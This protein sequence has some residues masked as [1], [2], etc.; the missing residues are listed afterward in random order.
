MR[1]VVTGASG[2]CGAAVA[3]AA[4]AAG[5][6]VVSVGRRPGPVGV[7]LHWDAESG[8]HPHLAGADAV[9]HLAAAVGDPGRAPAVERRFH[10]INVDA[11]ARLLDA[12][13]GRPV[14][15]VSSASVYAPGVHSGPVDEDGPIR[16]QHTAYGRTKAIGDR[17]AVGYGA[18]VLRPRAVYGPGDPHLL[19]R[20][21]RAVRAGRALLP[22][23]DT[24]MSLT[25]VENLADACVAALG[26]KSGPYNI[27]DAHP[28]PRDATIRAVLKARPLHLPVPLVNAA[29]ALAAKVRKAPTLTPY[30]VDQLANGLVLDLTRATEQGYRPARTLTDFLWERQNGVNRIR[31]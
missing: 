4:A 23:P 30:A 14:V 11:T 2:F 1:I 26:W 13:A 18:V 24:R 29:A 10:R 15:H 7:H 19:P 6:E 3:R 28:Y 17:L 12:A 25:A 20:L 27:A 16:D 22:G 31:R 8:D 5:H 9:I 21:R